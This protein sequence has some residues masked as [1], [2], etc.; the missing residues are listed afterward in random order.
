MIGQGY[1][2][3]GKIKEYLRSEGLLMDYEQY[4]VEQEMRKRRDDIREEFAERGKGGKTG[5]RSR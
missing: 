3:L 5:V 4:I 1:E 2:I